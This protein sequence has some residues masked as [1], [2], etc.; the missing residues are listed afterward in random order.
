[1]K[2]AA[3]MLALLAG[4]LTAGCDSCLVDS[5][6]APSQRRSPPP[7]LLAIDAFSDAVTIVNAADRRAP[8][9]QT[10][11]G[12][13]TV[14]LRRGVERMWNDIEFTSPAGKLVCYDAVLDTSYGVIIIELR[15]DL[16]PNHVRNFIALARAGFY[17][18]LEFERV[19]RQTP[20]GIVITRLELGCPFGLSETVPAHLGYC[21]KSEISPGAAIVPGAIGA[22]R[23]VGPDTA[24]C[25]FYITLGR[26]PEMDGTETVFG[27]VVLGLDTA[28]RIGG[29]QQ[30]D[31]RRPVIRMMT[32]Q[33]REV[34]PGPDD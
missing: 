9:E 17:E 12:L 15:P 4:P 20:D 28:R 6:P 26:S 11:S 7:R 2:R 16:A 22:C 31:R 3:R 19:G 32:I 10:A 21:L 29:G 8:P 5:P 18:G 27:H 33:A 1:M 30:N 34:D 14:G 25:R 23:D 24:G 13:S